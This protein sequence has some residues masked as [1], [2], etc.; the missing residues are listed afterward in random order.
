MNEYFDKLYRENDQIVYKEALRILGNTHDAEDVT[1][2]VFCKLYT[3]MKGNR[4]IQNIP[5]W[6]KITART[7]SIDMIRKSSDLNTPT[8]EMD[9]RQKD[10]VDS[11]LQKAFTDDMLRNL[12]RKNRMWFEYITMRYMLEMS[13]EEIALVHDTT[14][15][16]VKHAITRAKKYLSHKYF[17]DRVDYICPL[18]LTLLLLIF[19]NRI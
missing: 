3:Y 13:L 8:D 9:L 4:N 2:E 6:L 19:Q 7:T 11:L 16:A 10:F 18:I 15:A 5:G 1:I 17:Y 14:P 12:Y